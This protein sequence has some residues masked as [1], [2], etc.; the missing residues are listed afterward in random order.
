MVN[1]KVSWLILASYLSGVAAARADS[2]PV[3]KRVWRFE[4][5][6]IMHTPVPYPGAARVQGLVAG[7]GRALVRLDRHGKVLWRTLLIEQFDH[8]KQSLRH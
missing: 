3:P 1:S 6:H 8:L 7:D 5:Q 4:S 2:W